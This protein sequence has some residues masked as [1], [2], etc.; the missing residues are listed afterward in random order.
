M[1][2]TPGYYLE[3][4]R[5]EAYKGFTGV[6]QFFAKTALRGVTGGA[7]AKFGNVVGSNIQNGSGIF[8]AGAGV[9]N[10]ALTTAFSFV[11]G[12]GISVLFERFINKREM[13]VKQRQLLELYRPQIAAA[14]GVPVKETH[15]GHLAAVSQSVPFFGKVLHDMEQNRV[16]KNRVS[17]AS[18]FTSFA[19][20]LATSVALGFAAVTGIVAI[21]A[22]GAVGLGAYYSSK[23]VYNKIVDA[24]SDRPQVDLETKMRGILKLREYNRPVPHDLVM[25]VMA[26]SNPEL[27]ARIKQEFGKPYFKLDDEQRK[28]AMYEFGDEYHLPMVQYG[29]T[30]GQIPVYE[31]PFVANGTLSGAKA[32]P[33]Y[34]EYWDSVKEKVGVGRERITEAG[35]SV[36]S[37]FHKEEGKEEVR[38]PEMQEGKPVVGKWTEHNQARAANRAATP[39]YSPAG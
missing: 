4:A 23:A 38:S 33:F 24:T 28:K 7:T 9:G 1:F 35:K 32:V 19:A 21:L 17:L 13:E 15:M 12:L 10:L 6:R 39:Y 36:A 16:V 31:L 11:G 25:E 37:R 8:A 34:E 20:V 29:I 3:A 22:L 18:N 26:D 27:A 2:K 30:T 14:C 5:L